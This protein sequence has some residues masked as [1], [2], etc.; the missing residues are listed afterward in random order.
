METINENS[1]GINE[2]EPSQSN[3]PNKEILKTLETKNE[4][5]NIK[6]CLDNVTLWYEESV[7]LKDEDGNGYKITSHS[8]EDDSSRE[9]SLNSCEE[10]LNSYLKCKI[11]VKVGHKYK[12]YYEYDEETIYN[13]EEITIKSIEVEMEVTGDGEDDFTYETKIITDKGEIPSY[14]FW[15]YEINQSSISPT[16][17]KCEEVK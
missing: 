9:E 4:Q 7:I 5:Y 17:C 8:A 12:L 15:N 14:Y 16:I 13:N 10:V 3:E 1:Q 2:K 11:P 6:K